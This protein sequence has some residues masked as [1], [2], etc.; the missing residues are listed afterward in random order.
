MKRNNLNYFRRF[1][2]I[3]HLWIIL[4]ISTFNLSSFHAFGEIR[5]MEPGNGMKVVTG[6][7]LSPDGSPLSEVT[8][9]AGQTQS[10]AITDENGQFAVALDPETPS[11]TFSK[12]GYQAQQ[13][14]T[15]GSDNPVITLKPV[16]YV[17]LLFSRQ[18]QQHV[19]E[20]VSSISGE[21]VENLPG[22]NRN[23]VLGGRFTGLI[24]QQNNGEPGLEGSSLYIRG[25]RTLGGARQT[26]YILVDGYWRND[27]N[28]INPHDIESITV[29][30]DAASTAMYGL[31]GS[32]GVVLITTKRGKDEDIKVSLDAKYGLQTPTRIP[33]YLDSYNYAYLYNEAQRNGG[34]TDDKY[35]ATALD[36]YRTG[37]D[38]YN[39]PNIDWGKEFLKKYSTQQDYNLSIRGGNKAVRYYASAGYVAN[40]G[41]YNVD[42]NANTYNTNADF[43]LFRLRSNI[44]VQVTKEL[45]VSMEIG[46]RQDKRNY[47]GLRSNSASRIF[48]VLYQLPPNIFPIFREDGSL[49]GNSQYTNNPYGLLNYSGYSIY[50]V[51]NTDAAFKVK[52]DMGKLVKGLSARGAVSFDSYFEQTINRNKGFVVYYKN[53]LGEFVEMGVKDPA[54][55]QN[56]SSVGDNQRI[57]DMQFGFDYDRNFGKH[58]VSG[59]LFAEQTSYAGDGSVMPHYYQGIMGRASY[60]Y[61]NRYIGQV[62]FGYQGS[63]QIS[64]DNRY[65]LFPALSAGWIIS[66]ESFMDNNDWV[67]FLK[68]RA[69]HGLTGNDSNIGYFQ[70]LSFFEKS[71]SYLIGDNLASFGGYR[72][73]ALGV[74]GITCEKTRKTDIGIDGTFFN[75]HFN[76]SA[77]LFFEKTTGII[78]DLNTIPRMLGTANIP[79]GNAGIVENKGFELSMGYNNTVGDFS[80][81]VSGN[82]SF[83]RNKIIDMQEQ[84][85]PFAFNYR[86][87]HPIGSQ[88]GLQ[89]IGFFNDES[90][91]SSSPVQTY[92]PVRPGDLKYRDLTN[93]NKIDIDDISMIGKSW[94]PEMVYGATINLAYKGFDFNALIQGVENVDKKLSGSVYWEFYPNGLGKVME[95]HLD[96]WAYY[97]ELGIDTRATATYPRLNIEGDN[98]NNKAPNSDFWLKDASY[99]R[100]KSVELGYTLPVNI[101][102]YLHL[103]NLRIYA[104]GYNLLTSDKIKVIDPESPGDGIAYPIQRI[105]NIG[106]TA[107]F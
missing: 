11:L 22:V 34:S 62:S 85:F 84:E 78:L 39:Y 107:Q 56:G 38:P 27:A 17:D 44:D 43:E 12:E 47:P 9:T 51:R 46:V 96:R 71:G 24:V 33:K 5:G 97:P 64:D 75:N 66:E 52:Y 40:T 31:R 101:V 36:A 42:K 81:G 48:N 7:V 49:A 4:L 19:T 91:I 83:A 70:K 100:L 68:I 67:N 90:Q 79:T 15:T 103:S 13:V 10:S 53:E 54:T 20:A 106:I 2:I 89:S 1:K 69:S 30:K 73:G 21:E 74:P 86:T 77:D 37:T 105:V 80:Y 14:A 29:L 102:K 95:H 18:P 72:E 94:L 35:D 25:L 98:T 50:N 55:Q 26:P 58:S 6:K 57:F 16:K 28:Y 59:T 82:F 65:V 92:G 63:E 41:L 61:N 93:D 60:V 23:N 8:V 32:N 45:Q 104:S 88:F 99:L 87:G 76:L 3:P